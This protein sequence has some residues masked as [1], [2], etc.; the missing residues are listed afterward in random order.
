MTYDEE[1]DEYYFKKLEKDWYTYVRFG[2]RRLGKGTIR[3]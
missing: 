2:R 3:K 1:E